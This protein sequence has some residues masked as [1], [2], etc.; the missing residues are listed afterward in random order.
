MVY[1]YSWTSMWRTVYL[2]RGSSDVTRIPVAVYA[3]ERVCVDD[4]GPSGRYHHSNLHNH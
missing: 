3:R 4:H 2:I 1:I